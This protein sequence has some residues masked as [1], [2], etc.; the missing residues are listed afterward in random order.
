MRAVRPVLLSDNFLCDVQHEECAVAL[1]TLAEERTARA[2]E[3]ARNTIQLH[4]EYEQ[5]LLDKHLYVDRT[6]ASDGSG[7]G[8]NA[9][10][11]M[12]TSHYGD[13]N[14]IIATMDAHLKELRDEKPTG[15]CSA[16]GG[17]ALPGGQRLA[18]SAIKSLIS[19][20]DNHADRYSWRTA[21]NP[22]KLIK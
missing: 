5:Q 10:S 14:R 8:F 15:A 13:H 12:R 20:F 2:L 7:G 17:C 6:S 11:N 9:D 3:V 1:Q 19:D 4:F 21:C 18:L 16:A 22:V